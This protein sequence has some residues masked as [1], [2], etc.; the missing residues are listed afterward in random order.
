MLGY[1]LA[2]LF[3]LNTMNYMDRLLFGVGQ[4]LIRKDLD[5]S[6][7]QLGLLGGPAFALLYVIAAFP[8]ARLAERGNR[9]TIISIAFGAWSLMTGLCGLAGSFAQLLVGRA[10][11]SI[12]EAGC[13]PPSHS[14]ISDYFPPERRTTAMSVYGTAGPVGALIAAIGG[15]W[16]AQHYGWRVTFLLCGGFGVIAAILFRLTLREP[17]RTHQDTPVSLL[18]ALRVLLGKRSFRTIAAAGALAGFASYSNNQYMVSFLMRAHGLSIGTA[19][20][21]LGLVIGGVGIFVTLV[22]G[23]IIDRSGARFP[24]IRSWLPAGG[25]LWSGIFFAIAFT[26]RDTPAAIALLVT[27]SFGQHFY[28]PAMYTVAQDV[29]PPTMR[30]TAAALLIAIISVV[31]YG[32][33]PP[34]VG[35]TSDIIRQFALA[36]HGTDAAAC[37]RAASTACEAAKSDGLRLSLSIGSVGFIFAALLFWT[38]ARTIVKDTHG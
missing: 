15:G 13:A 11:V 23:P 32:L 16:L 22:T 37:A 3:V 12:G 4:E 36:A 30:A 19:G 29:A 26:V 20:V 33:G 34:L 2:A 17:T 5:L 21:V 6:D 14:L 10:G 24:R 9:V 35:F 1:T 31:G 38:S 7:F 27:A 28:M 25:M 8:I 18:T